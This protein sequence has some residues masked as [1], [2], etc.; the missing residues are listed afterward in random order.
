MGIDVADRPR[1]N[2]EK[3][4]AD[5]KRLRTTKG[6]HPRSAVRRLITVCPQDIESTIDTLARARI[7]LSKGRIAVCAE[8][9]QQ[10]ENKLESFKPK[11]GS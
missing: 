9:I 1:T 5:R 2:R 3:Q 10:V 4:M 8:L 11:K 7:H 6:S